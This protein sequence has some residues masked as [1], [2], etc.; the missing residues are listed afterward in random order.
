MVENRFY[1]SLTSLFNKIVGNIKIDS[2]SSRAQFE[3]T[4]DLN[5]AAVPGQ[6]GRICTLAEVNEHTIFTGIQNT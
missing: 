1:L 2:L 3:K 6:H 5:P 4:R